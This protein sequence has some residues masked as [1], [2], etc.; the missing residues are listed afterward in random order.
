MRQFQVIRSVAGPA[1]PQTQ[2]IVSR[3]RHSSRRHHR[4]GQPQLVAHVVL[5]IGQSRAEIFE[6][7]LHP[8]RLEFRLTQDLFFGMIIPGRKARG[9]KHNCQDEQSDREESFAAQRPKETAMGGA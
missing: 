9:N 3:F 4:L 6:C 8:A 1:L 2:Q 7:R 5:G